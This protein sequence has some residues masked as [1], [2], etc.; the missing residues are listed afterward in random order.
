MAA[1]GL[2]PSSV[3]PMASLACVWNEAGVGWV[4]KMVGAIRYRRLCKT[5]RVSS[6]IVCYR[7][8]AVVAFVPCFRFAAILFALLCPAVVVVVVVL[9][10]RFFLHVVRCALLLPRFAVF[11]ALRRCFLRSPLFAPPPAVLLRCR[12]SYPSAVRRFL[13]P[14][15]STLLFYSFPLLFLAVAWLLFF[16]ID[17]LSVSVV[18]SVTLLLSVPIAFDLC[19]CCR[20]PPPP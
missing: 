12:R 13:L 18:V 9:I 15:M 11:R 5:S 19:C 17:L 3:P 16:Q 6:A 1:D 20:C 4:N 14:S 10:P 8:I 7:V 2:L